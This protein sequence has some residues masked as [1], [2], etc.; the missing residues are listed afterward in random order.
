MCPTLAYGSKTISK[1]TG[2]VRNYIFPLV[3]VL[4][5]YRQLNDDDIV[6]EM[7]HRLNSIDFQRLDQ[8]LQ[9]GSKIIADADV[10]KRTQ[11]LLA[12]TNS[13]ALIALYESLC[14]VDYHRSNEH[15]A[16]SFDYVFEQVQSRKLLR[17][18]DI[19]PAMAQFLF[20]PD[21]YRLRFARGA[22][23]KLAQPLTEEAFDW[24][25]H[26]VLSEAIVKVAQMPVNP[27]DAHR[28]WQGFLLMLD[29]M[30][31]KLITHTLK[32]M[33][34]QPSIYQLALWHLPS[35]T[36]EV[37][38][39]IIEVIRQLLKKSPKSFWDAM[40]TISPATVAEQIFASPGYTKLIGKLDASDQTSNSPAVAWI[41][42]FIASLPA[43]H[44]HDACRAV[45]LNLLERIQST[46]YPEVARQICCQAGLRALCATLHSF[47][48]ADY[49]IH[50]SSSLI[51]I[52]DIIGLVDSY[53]DTIIGCAD[54]ANGDES[55]LKLKRLGM[56][57]IKDA[58]ALDCKALR[59]E[60]LALEGGTPIQQ[61]A[62]NH[63]QPIWQAVLDIFRPGNVDLAK[64][65]LAA[66]SSLTGLDELWPTNKK[67]GEIPKDHHQYNQEFKQLNDN[68]SRI[69][70]RLTDFA[71]SELLQLANE[72]ETARPFF[73]ALFSADQAIYEAA[74][75]V[76]K[77]MTGESV[78]RYAIKSLLDQG[79]SSV[80][81]SMNFAVNQ[82]VKA[83]TFS[84]VPYM[85]KIGH[86]V[87]NALCGN[88][89]ILRTRND[90][91]AHEQ[92]AVMAWWAQQWRA[93][94]V[95]FATIEQW[96]WKVNRKIEYL[97]EFC[98]DAMEYAEL[99]FDAHA[100]IAT[101][102]REST[103]TGDESAFV[104]SASSK[105]SIKKVLQ[106]VSINV[107]GLTGMLRLR[108][109][110]LVSII[111][112]ILSKLLRCLGDYELEIAEYALNFIKGA[113]KREN[114]RGF[115]KT[116]MSFQE[117]ADLQRA[118][119]DHQGLQV[120]EM[121]PSTTA[122]K[123]LTIDGWS[124]SA[125]GKQH[126]PNLP[127]K[128]QSGGTATHSRLTTSTN[129]GRNL[130]EEIQAKQAAKT[131]QSA[132]FSQ[133]FRES[134]RKAE[135]EKRL[136][137]A[138]AIAKA[139]ALRLPAAFV[140]GEGSG[141]HGL[142]GVAG[143]DHAPV[144]SEIMVGSSDEDSDDDDDEDETN[145]L[146]KTRKETSKKVTEYEES[147]R[148]ALLKQKGPVRK[149]KVQRSAKDLRARVEPNMDGLYNEILNWEIFHAGDTPPGDY[150]CRRID[151]RYIE[152][153]LYKKTFGPLL[154]SEVW[155]SL[156]T[157]KDENNFQAI[158]IKVLNRLSVDKFMEVSTTMPMS[159]NRELK[160]SERDIVLLSKG[161]NP[162]NDTQQP[163]CLAR[164]DRTTRKKDVIEITY[165]VS[166]EINSALLQ[167]LV[168]NGKLYALKIADM[169]TTQREF[170][171]LSSLEYY[172][173]CNE[174]LE[175]KPSPIQKYGAEKIS[176]V[177]S[178]Y[179]LN[180]GQAQAILS[181]NDNDGF[182]L[183][184]GYVF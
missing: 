60:Y 92:S 142:G 112:R 143:K 120:I 21:V 163:H 105:E 72:R 153:G 67:T 111:T 39:L 152:L 127:Q 166:R 20:D 157:A 170:A 63:S 116:N 10:T 133:Q 29:H 139:K 115:K 51:I 26:D 69:F 16:K 149:T 104:K 48:R 94:D 15:L 102:V 169:T 91:S 86:D 123:Q 148:R 76:M 74:V 32:A 12:M 34:V 97:Q 58:L 146:V 45:L 4:I 177:S 13:V 17:I 145:A 88:T 164:V 171:A 95:V 28:F 113:C 18:A 66:T 128:S 44:Q 150:E 140:K 1:R 56:A 68:I 126:E 6:A 30:D 118:L 160:M 154:I 79:L 71:P 59:A 33:E 5:T 19:L 73:S 87:L 93:L 158:E 165:R 108:D 8:G 151:N 182:T 138:E 96:G 132:E 14:C 35:D 38:S 75:E 80:L 147:R 101:A 64:S 106:T 3:H 137:K 180:K 40:Q 98:R 176:D 162:L 129:K 161:S 50:P 43:A 175:A 100:I 54:L 2:N 25:I 47:V 78:K 36:E 183:I 136:L 65:I 77:T 70:E 168:P 9:L 89:G 31:E 167:Y 159:A 99:L 124:K 46:R 62:R 7:G 131:T 125:D 37:V 24:V 141:I 22:W 179:S 52:N 61:V 174:I 155:R 55:H 82:V 122:K 11:S 27:N 42:D 184:Q 23:E 85:L 41:P 181:A 173:L 84:P 109:I 130:M 119:D 172:D 156:V 49:K 121:A 90:L 81:H 114:E 103:P 135:E 83:H 53:K 57:V 110:Y 107:N 178:K 117:K 144:R 134:R